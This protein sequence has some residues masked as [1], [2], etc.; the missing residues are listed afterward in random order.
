VS[1]VEGVKR[2]AGVSVRVCVNSLVVFLHLLSSIQGVFEG[3]VVD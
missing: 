2:C 1:G 3:V